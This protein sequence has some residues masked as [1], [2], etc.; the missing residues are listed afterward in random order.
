MCKAFICSIWAY[1]TLIA[2]IL[3]GNDT[4]HGVTVEEGSLDV[5]VA[6]FDSHTQTI[7]RLFILNAFYVYV[8]LYVVFFF[9]IWRLANFL[10]LQVRTGQ[11]VILKNEILNE[12]S[13]LGGLLYSWSIQSRLRMKW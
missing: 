5:T 10:Y 12:I 8:M 7:P 9:L 4:Q 13:F 3:Q 2:D 1:S 6:V 11:K